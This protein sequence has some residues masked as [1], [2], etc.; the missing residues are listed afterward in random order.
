MS[1]GQGVYRAYYP[2]KPT[3][4]GDAEITLDDAR[5]FAGSRRYR[6]ELG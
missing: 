4:S 3:L 5:T 1:S 2:I 6:E